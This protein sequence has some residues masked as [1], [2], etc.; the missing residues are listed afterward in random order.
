MNQVLMAS[1][2]RHILLIAMGL[3]YQSFWL[4]LAFLLL[5]FFPSATH[6]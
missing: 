5:P 3:L 1:L 6:R 4:A 2:S